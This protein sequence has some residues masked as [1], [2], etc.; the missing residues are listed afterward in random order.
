MQCR[1]LESCKTNNDTL[2]K[3]KIIPNAKKRLNLVYGYTKFSLQSKNNIFVLHKK[4]TVRN[5]APNGPLCLSDSVFLSGA[6]YKE[7]FC[8]QPCVKGKL[9]DAWFSFV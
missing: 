5:S 4:A 6:S 1:S 3:E 8:L 2:I 9:M 7:A